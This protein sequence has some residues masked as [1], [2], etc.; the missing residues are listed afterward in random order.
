VAVARFQGVQQAVAGRGVVPWSKPTAASVMLRVDTLQYSQKI[1]CFGKQ[2][3]LMLVPALM[4]LISLE[5]QGWW[6][7]GLLQCIWGF[8][9]L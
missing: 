8:A 3:R 9:S 2:W 1:S 6:Q 5:Q 4:C 7:A